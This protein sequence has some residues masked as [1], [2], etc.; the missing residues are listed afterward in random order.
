MKPVV[1]LIAYKMDDDY[2]GKKDFFVEARRIDRDGRMA[3]ARPVTYDLM[4]E[5][6][7]GYSEVH[8]EVPHGILPPN[9]L[10]ADTRKGCEKYV[11]YNLPQRKMHYFSKNLAIDNGEYNVPGMVYVTENG[12]LQVFS[13]KGTKCCADTPLFR[14]PFFNTGSDGDVCLGSG[15]AAMPSDPS[16]KDVLEHWEKKF[17][18]TEFSGLHGGNPTTENLVLVT[19]ASKDAPFDEGK[20]KPV[21]KK[22]KDLIK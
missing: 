16:F 4:N 6:A 8:N 14:A 17:W 3:E 9:M 2:K 22:V 19:Q 11:W 13:F 15:K 18:L 7:S 5:L 21:N 1:A 20:L 10:Y 12:K